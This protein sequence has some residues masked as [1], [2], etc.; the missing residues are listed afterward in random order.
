MNPDAVLLVS[1]VGCGSDHQNDER[2]WYQRA[3]SWHFCWSHRPSLHLYSRADA[4]YTF[5]VGE[6]ATTLRKPVLR[7]LPRN[8]RQSSNRYDGHAAE[9]YMSTYVLK[10]ALDEPFQT[11]RSFVMLWPKQIMGIRTSFLTTASVLTR[12]AITRGPAD[13]YANH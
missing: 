10:D 1:V 4:D 9:T 8:S 12:L 11:V 7:K 5:T 6:W 3:D 2:T 13:H